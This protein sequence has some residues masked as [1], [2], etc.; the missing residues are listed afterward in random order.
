MKEE[1]N[2]LIITESAAGDKAQNDEDGMPGGK[3][4]KGEEKD[5][6]KKKKDKKAKK[7]H[8]KGPLC[9]LARTDFIEKNFKEYAALVHKPAYICKKCGR[10]AND[11]KLLCK[12]V[13]MD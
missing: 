1:D 9:K 4:K 6:D 11:K 7:P 2:Q 8:V 3:L 12:P 5:P 13:S 10:A